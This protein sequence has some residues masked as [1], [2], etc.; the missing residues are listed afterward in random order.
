MNIE[1]GYNLWAH[2][3]DIVTNPTRDLEQKVLQKM[4]SGRSYDHIIE[5]GCGTGKNTPWLSERCNKLTSVDFSESMLEVAKQH[6]KLENVS[7]LLADITK[8]WKFVNADLIT[9]SLVLEHI[10]ALPHIFRQAYQSLSANGELYICELH[11]YRQLQGKSA[12]FLI[13][14]ELVKIP[15]FIHHLSEYFNT[16]IENGFICKNFFEWFDETNTAIP[17]LCSFIFYKL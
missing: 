13:Q 14:E 4:L 11:P 9:C 7:F 3:Y 15:F 5:L 16:A 10:S 6:K 1:E 17:R 12:E 2:S 8:P